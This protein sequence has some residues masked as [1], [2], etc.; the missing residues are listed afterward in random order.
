MRIAKL[1]TLGCTLSLAAC[2][3]QV[4]LSSDELAR[5][6]SELSAAE[7]DYAHNSGVELDARRSL[8][9]TEQPMLKKFSFKRVMKQLVRQSD[10]RGLKAKELFQQ[11]WDTQNPEAE[12]RFS[13]GVHCDDQVD[14]ELGPVL[15]GFPYSCRP[16]PAEGSQA[17]CNPFRDADC[18]YVPVG[19]FNRF[20]LAQEDGGSCGEYRIVFAK[21]SGTEDKLDRNLI[22]FEA[23]M[24]NPYPWAGLR[25]CRPIV[26]FWAA[27]SAE[28]NMK[29]RARMLERFYFKGLGHGIP[30]VVH[31][32]H[33]GDNEDGLGQ[34]R[35][36]QFM[37]RDTGEFVWSLREFKLRQ[38]C[39]QKQKKH[40]KRGRHG[41]KYCSLA[42]VPDTNKLNPYGPLFAPTA[43]HAK[44]DEFQSFFVSQ[45]G[46]LAAD[47]VEGIS[48]QMDDRFNS[49]QS[50]ASGST[51]TDYLVQFEGGGD[52]ADA[53][54][55][56]LDAVGSD[57]EPVDI[58]ARAQTQSCAGC[59]RLSNERD[60]GDGLTWPSSL[61]FTH[62][63]ERDIEEVDGTYRF[64]I[65]EALTGTFLP[66]R[67]EV[68]QD[69]L[70]GRPRHA[71]SYAS[72][73]GHGPR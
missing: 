51:E 33:Y 47:S 64:A 62:I 3:G 20:D 12:A 38:T 31:V 72:L 48:L 19:L 70:L 22:I 1:A 18:E 68:M 61:G 8:V 7:A 2:T 66:A 39:E 56:E 63:S 69:F 9:I 26:G 13:G 36:N 28:D 16:A 54:Q 25:G 43:T 10:V 5:Q 42:F 52:L 60:L 65:S 45:V 55:Y 58:V 17:T 53:I 71:L 14:A 30:P 44:Q 50:Q 37:Q 40:K 23:A 57:L 59:H 34:V 35:T 29:K 27:L 11:W 67:L 49:A 73:G 6:E 32:S 4:G 41:R 21:Q 24:P 46:A 15:N